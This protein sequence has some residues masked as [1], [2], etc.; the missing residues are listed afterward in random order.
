[1]LELNAVSI[2]MVPVIIV[3]AAGSVILISK[4]GG[5]A[6]SKNIRRMKGFSDNEDTDR[7]EE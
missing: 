2:L 5:K 4:V 7:R 3:I 6:A 1:M